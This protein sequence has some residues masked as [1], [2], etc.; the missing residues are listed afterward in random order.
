MCMTAGVV[1]PGVAVL[2]SDTRTNLY[3]DDGTV[4]RT[5]RGGKVVRT[6]GGFLTGS[7]EGRLLESV[8]SRAEG[9]AACEQELGALIGVPAGAR[10]PA[11]VDALIEGR[12]GTSCRRVLVNEDGT[13][14]WWCWSCSHH[15][16]RGD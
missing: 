4:I 10:R 1:L 11:Q 16:D 6:G 9:G 3:Y 7:G 8:L 13:E 14:D 5:D 2:A 15:E 12:P